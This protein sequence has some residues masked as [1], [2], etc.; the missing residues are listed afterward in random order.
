[1]SAPGMTVPQLLDPLAEHRSDEVVVTTMSVVVGTPLLPKSNGRGIFTHAETF[2]KYAVPN[3]VEPKLRRVLVRFSLKH[4]TQL[5][6]RE[7]Q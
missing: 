6:N 5:P 1:M 7:P 3:A 2:E 4:T